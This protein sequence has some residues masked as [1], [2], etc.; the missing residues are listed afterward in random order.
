MTLQEM[1]AH[2]GHDPHLFAK[3]TGMSV[4]TWYRWQAQG[5]IN[6]AGQVKLQR[7]TRGKL[8]ADPAHGG[9]K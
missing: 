4:P 9:G 8:K 7:L 1:Q 3:R 2:Y 5:Y 6:M